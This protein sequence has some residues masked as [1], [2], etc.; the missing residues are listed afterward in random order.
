M[1]ATSELNL[2]SNYLDVIPLIGD[3]ESIAHIAIFPWEKK[4]TF[5]TRMKRV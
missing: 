1:H 4:T 2:F 5:F 3:I